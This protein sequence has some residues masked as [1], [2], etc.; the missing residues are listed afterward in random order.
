MTFTSEY[1][2]CQV[3]VAGEVDDTL[4]VLQHSLQ[5]QTP[6]ALPVTLTATDGWGL[7]YE[8]ATGTERHT[9]ASALERAEW[10]YRRLH[11]LIAGQ[12]ASHDWYRLHTA[13][14]RVRD[15]TVLIGGHSGAGK[16]TLAVPLGLAGA[17]VFADE[18]VFVQRD[19][20]LPLLRRAHVKASSV[21]LLPETLI[22]SAV[23]LP[24]DPPL[25]TV[26]PV[27][28]T[29]VRS[30]TELVPDTIVLLGDRDAAETTL[31]PATEA[32]AVATILSEAAQFNA[33]LPQLVAAVA[34]L[35]AHTRVLRL[36]GYSGTR[37]VEALHERL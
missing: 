29:S 22:E 24:Y 19:R 34:G 27:K 23:V 31:T 13:L 14:V 2:W 15:C 32:E 11:G 5:S 16:T 4:R 3:T 6:H 21:D 35:L 10:A 17:D 36:D 37:G 25:F 33:H 12:A 1:H 20:V 8:S 18:G 28:F 26:D 9:F 30:V 7:V